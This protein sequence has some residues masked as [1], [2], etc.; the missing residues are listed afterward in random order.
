MKNLFDLSTDEKKRIIALHE[1]ATK[2][3][4]LVEQQVIQG[5]ANDPY[6]YKKTGDKVEYAPKGTENWKVQT[7]PKGVQAI[8]NLFAKSAPQNTPTPTTTT[9]DGTGAGS[10]GTTTTSTGAT[11]TGATGTGTGATVT[12][13]TGTGTTGAGATGADTTGTGAGGNEPSENP[14][15][16][17]E[18]I[19]NNCGEI[20]NSYL[21]RLKNYQAQ[22]KGKAL[23]AQKDIAKEMSKDEK[24]T[25]NYCYK[26]YKPKLLPDEK[27][28]YSTLGSNFKKFLSASYKF[29]APAVVKM[30]STTVEKAADAGGEAVLKSLKIGDYQTKPASVTGESRYKET[31]LNRL[32][33]ESIRK[34]TKH[35]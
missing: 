6:Q 4:Y 25:F 11:G 9:T 17:R 26:L 29:L 16:L 22:M 30:M 33:K 1:G 12:G 2:R 31:D 27:T 35:L 23:D 3:L 24:K 32:I 28:N 15:E 10:T 8:N 13:T 5:G 18:K 21:E 19:T 20:W 7:N 14:N 34:N